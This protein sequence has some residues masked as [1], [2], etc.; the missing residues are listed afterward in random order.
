MYLV[1]EI[2][3]IKALVRSSSPYDYLKSKRLNRR[4]RNIVMFMRSLIICALV[5]LLVLKGN[6]TED[7]SLI[8]DIETT[9]RALNII[10]LILDSF[11]V[12]VYLYLV[13]Y[14]T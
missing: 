12:L 14:M 7:E 9:V 2:F 5:I 10:L 3:N 13:L 4:L 1:F 6:E 11:V 8:A